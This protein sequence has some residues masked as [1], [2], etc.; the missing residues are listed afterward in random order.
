MD[1]TSPQPQSTK[2]G[3]LLGIIVIL[4]LLAAGAA[5]F[6]IT[7]KERFDTPP[8]RETINV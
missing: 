2:I 7:L 1:D 5:Y 6:F 4:A 3:P 8:V